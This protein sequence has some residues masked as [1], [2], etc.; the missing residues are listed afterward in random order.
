MKYCVVG[1]SL[2]IAKLYMTLSYSKFTLMDKFIKVL[3]TTQ[4]TTYL[5][6]IQ[7]RSFIYIQG[8]IIGLLL[9]FAYLYYVNGIDNIKSHVCAFVS[10]V[11]VTNVIYYLLMPKST[12]MLDHIKGEKQITAW[13]NIYLYMQYRYITG[14]LIGILAYVFISYGVLKK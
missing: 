11:M 12:Y 4:R 1:F 2:L 8:M 7:E 5:S 3:N 14:I 9:G 13:K 10:I 6:I